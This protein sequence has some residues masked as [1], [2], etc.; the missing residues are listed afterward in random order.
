MYTSEEILEQLTALSHFLGDPGRDLA[1]LG[2][3]NTSARLDDDTFYVKASGQHLGT[4][5]SSGCCAVNFSRILPYFDKPVMSDAEVKQALLECKATDAS[6]VLPSVETFFHAY[7]L[8]MPN[9]NYI[10]H[11]HPIA[12]NAILCSNRAEEA[13]AG[14]LFP[15]EIVCCGIA[16]CFVEY[17]DPGIVLSKCIKLR[18][19]QYYEKYLEWPKV[20]VMQ[21]HGLIACGR[22]PKDVQT[23]TSMFVKTARTIIGTYA[24]GGPNFL[25]E[26]NVSRIHTRPDEH[27]RQRQIGQR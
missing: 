19:E 14:R 23:I 27:Y 1:I 8:T 3:G 10:G 20:I 2:E 13:L 21:N 16:P 12:V 24:M 17:T 5:T 25:T 26:E 6:E 11:T 18:V 4:I 7:L 9:V 22:T 15:D